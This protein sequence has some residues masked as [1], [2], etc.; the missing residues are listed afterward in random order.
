MKLLS[1][2]L[3]LT[4]P[5]SPCKTYGGIVASKSKGK[6]QRILSSDLFDLKKPFEQNT[7]IPSESV[8]PNSHAI[9]SILKLN[10]SK[11]SLP[12]SAIPSMKKL[13]LDIILIG[14]TKYLTSTF[15]PRISKNGYKISISVEA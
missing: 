1:S 5:N 9:I 13:A 15:L 8:K 10:V 12:S 7:I 3:Y 14:S 2:T 6:Y 11:A 4:L